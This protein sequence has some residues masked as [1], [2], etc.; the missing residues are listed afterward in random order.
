MCDLERGF[1]NGEGETGNSVS[2]DGLLVCNI[3]DGKNG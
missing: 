3:E 1:V 2:L